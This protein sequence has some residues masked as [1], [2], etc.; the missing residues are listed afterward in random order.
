M[1]HDILYVL[2]SS[3][4]NFKRFRGFIKSHVVYPETELVIN[5]MG[6]FYDE[7]KMAAIDWEAL[8][9]Y[10]LSIYSVRL[11]PDTLVTVKKL[12][13]HMKTFVP[14]TAHEEVVKM[15][16]EQDY[17]SRIKAET[18]KARDGEGSLEDIHEV[19]VKA[20]KEVE[21]FV[22]KTDVFVGSDLSALAEAVS[23]SGYEFRLM[24]LNRSLGLFRPGDF[25]IVAAR[26]EVGKTTFLAAEISYICPQLPKDRP[27]IWVNNEESSSKVMARIMQSALGLTTS[28]LFK[29]LKTNEE[30]FWKLMGGKDRILVTNGV[31]DKKTLEL[32][33]SEHN[34]GLIVFDQL[35]KVEGFGREERD[36][37]TLGKKYLWGRKLSQQYCPVIA[38]SQLSEGVDTLK[39]PPFPGMTYLRGSKTDKPGEAD[40]VITI[41]KLQTPLSPEDEAVRTIHVPK[42]KLAGGGKYFN[43]V[44]RHGK[45]IVKIDTLRARYE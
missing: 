31:N 15:L 2:G 38:A 12:I 11:K 10:V 4:V 33:F 14:T 20:L 42:N 40:A 30:N 1:D 7:K 44:E 39:D 24:E 16:I 3:Q 8:S 37:L 21:R 36:D 9:S 29:D 26:P 28:E 6:K 13:D 23:T 32:L 43:E 22:D 34:P 27:I 17:L 18:D 19:T 41:G 5:G 45:H 35:D 25:I